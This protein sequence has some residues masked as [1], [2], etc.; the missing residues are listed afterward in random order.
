MSPQRSRSPATHPNPGGTLSGG[1]AATGEASQRIHRRGLSA[2]LPPRIPAGTRISGPERPL[3]C[4]SVERTTGFEPATLTLA[5]FWSAST[6]LRHMRSRAAPFA[7]TS[8]GWWSVRAVVERSTT[9]PAAHEELRAYVM[10]RD[11]TPVVRAPLWRWP[12]RV[13][14]DFR[15]RPDFLARAVAQPHEDGGIWERCDVVVGHLERTGVLP[16]ARPRGR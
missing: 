16:K 8:T 3:T 5:T 14:R 10:S 4:S 9:R 13:L 2:D 15:R 6:P 12:R 11:G 1:D 7:R